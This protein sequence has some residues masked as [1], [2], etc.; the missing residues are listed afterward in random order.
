MRTDARTIRLLI[1]SVFALSFAS[2]CGLKGDLYI[3]EQADAE[4]TDAGTAD[5][6]AEENPEDEAVE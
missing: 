1:A 3:P 4:Q 5:A 6:T 2:G